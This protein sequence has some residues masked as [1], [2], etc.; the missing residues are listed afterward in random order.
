MNWFKAILIES[1][2]NQ[3]ERWMLIVCGLLRDLISLIIWK[4]EKLCFKLLFQHEQLNCCIPR[5]IHASNI[6]SNQIVRYKLKNA[7]LPGILA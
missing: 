2:F 7:Y 1:V 6:L 3:N 4:M 5:N